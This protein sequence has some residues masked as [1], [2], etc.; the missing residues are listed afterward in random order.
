MVSLIEKEH[1]SDIS[2]DWSTP[3]RAVVNADIAPLETFDE[4][5]PLGFAFYSLYF[6]RTGV[7]TRANEKLPASARQWAEDKLASG[8]LS[9]YRD[10]D[11]GALALLVYS[12]AEY[13]IPLHDDAQLATLVATET[14]VDG[15]LFES[16]FLTSL[17]AL[18]LSKTADGC[19]AHFVA[20]IERGTVL[21]SEQL[22][23]DPKALVAGFWCARAVHRT[24]LSDRLFTIAEDIS[25]SGIDHLDARVCSAAVLVENLERLSVGRRLEVAKFAKE[26][27]KSVGVEA[28]G[29][30]SGEII[31]VEEEN[32]LCERHASKI[33]ISVGLLCRDT[34]EAKSA[35]LLM[36]DARVAQWVRASVYSPICAGI[37]VAVVWTAGRVRSSHPIHEQ[38]VAPSFA[39]AALVLAILIAYTLLVGCFAGAL[40]A[41]FELLIGLGIRGKHKDEFAAFKAAWI[42]VKTYYKLEL[43]AALL[44][45]VL[46]DFL[47]RRE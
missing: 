30:N 28:V 8:K 10:R 17:I 26:A 45:T 37:A 38:L 23:N 6:L 16:Y 25:R 12:F 47:I 41:L 21:E 39:T 11:L 29:D 1:P 7:V 36:R 27:I 4:T 35:L 2:Y 14:Y 44:V 24:D 31:L 19:P 15:L 33:L 46:F 34:L 9:P 40:F 42:S 22:Q 18:G 3:L 13:G 20:A 43:L 5:D 32:F